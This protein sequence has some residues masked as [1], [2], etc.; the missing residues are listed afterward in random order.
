MK[1]SGYSSPSSGATTVPWFGT[2][3]DSYYPGK[4]YSFD[5]QKA[6]ENIG[7]HNILI[8]GDFKQES[9]T[10]YRKYLTN[11]H[12]HDSVDTSKY[13]NGTYQIHDGKARN[14]ALFLQDEYKFNEPWTMYAGLRYDHYKK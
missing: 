13:R 7:K 3:T 8:G 11:W 2:G 5:F 4:T 1:T 12:D 10:Q 6:W 9:F 14:I